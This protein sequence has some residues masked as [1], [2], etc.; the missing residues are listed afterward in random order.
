[1]I[2]TAN[3]LFFCAPNTSFL[4]I[5][6]FFS[7]KLSS[8]SIKIQR[9]TF[10]RLLLLQEKKERTTKPIFDSEVRERDSFFACDFFRVIIQLNSNA[11]LSPR[12]QLLEHVFMLIIKYVMSYLKVCLIVPS[13]EELK[14][15]LCRLLTN[16]E[17]YC[18]VELSKILEPLTNHKHLIVV[19][20]LA[21]FS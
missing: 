14:E 4:V 8:L 9:K 16:Y 5:K 20:V 15:F 3:L 21:F 11:T 13:R 1:M 17:L 6:L 7:Q 18:W 2:L 10:E 19:E 12:L